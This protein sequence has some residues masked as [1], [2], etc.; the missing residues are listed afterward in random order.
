LLVFGEC[1]GEVSQD[2]FEEWNQLG[3]GFLFERG[4]GATSGLLNLLVGIKNGLE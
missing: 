1:V 3:S 4:K 2:W